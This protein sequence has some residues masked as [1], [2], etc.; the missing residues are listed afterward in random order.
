MDAATTGQIAELMGGGFGRTARPLLVCDVDEVVLH[1]VAPFEQVLGERGYELR[2]RS[3]KLTGNIFHVESRREATQADV[4]AA[5]TQLF[6]EQERRQELVEGAV[7]ALSDLARDLDIV[8]LTNMPH[9]F[10]EIRRR[11]L[12]ALGLDHPLLTNTGT[13]ATGIAELKRGRPA[14]GFVDDTPVN[15]AQV[16]EAHDDVDLFHLMADATFRAMVGPIDGVHVS[17][18][19]WAEAAVHMRRVLLP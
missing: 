19:D 10:R 12:A 18:G 13:K 11:H 2:T 1:L 4:W 6:E 15:L 16:A 8:F 7:E 9:D 17:T 14:V 5:L 3:F